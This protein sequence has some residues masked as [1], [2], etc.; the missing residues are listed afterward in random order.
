MKRKLA[1]PL[2]FCITGVGVAMH[3]Q[4]SSSDEAGHIL[5]LETAWNHALEGKDTNALDML[6]AKNMI[7]QGL[8][9]GADAEDG[10]SRGHQGPELPA[11]AGSQREDQRADVRRDGHRLRR[12]PGKESREGQNRPAPG[13][14]C[15]YLG[16]GR[17]HLAMRGEHRRHH[18][19]ARAEFRLTLL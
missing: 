2:F 5:A 6:L 19:L 1:V 17:R 18:S 12:L 7:A 11:G 15:G 8:R 9:R 3:G 13:I 16:K 10:F 14:V 4:G